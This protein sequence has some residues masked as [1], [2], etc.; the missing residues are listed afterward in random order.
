MTRDQQRQRVAERRQ[1]VDELYPELRS[2]PKVASIIGCSYMTV[3]TD[4]EALGIPR[5]HHQESLALADAEI[6][7]AV[8]ERRERVRVLYPELRSI[9]RVAA[10]LECSHG[11]VVN[12]LA[13]LGLSPG[14]RTKRRGRMGPCRR[15]GKEEWRYE[16]DIGQ[17]PHGEFC[18][19]ECWNLWRWEH[20]KIT[21]QIGD[22]GEYHGV[23]S[24]SPRRRTGKARQKWLGRWN[25][26]KGAAG[27][28]EAGR[29]KGGRPPKMTPEQQVEILRLDGG[30][31]EKSTREIA[32][33]VFGDRR[34]YKR[35]QRFL[36]R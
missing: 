4:L 11:T 10:E 36:A 29:A 23:I 2:S 5:M 6:Q 20:G 13:A 22:D 24:L 19:R 26:S 21:S 17:N 25:G 12:D 35:V 32:E 16:C 31:H 34:Y 14:P 9:R 3:C 1:R 33:I 15:C 30:I 7:R 28:I 18:T 27:G 8:K